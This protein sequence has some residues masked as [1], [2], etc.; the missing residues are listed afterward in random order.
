MA[1]PLTD[2]PDLRLSHNKKRE[3][4]DETI[5]EIYLTKVVVCARFGCGKHLTITE[6][7]FGP[8]CGGAYCRTDHVSHQ[9]KLVS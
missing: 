6:Q 4:P 8:K 9:G 3:R 7:L 2:N 5:L 1:I